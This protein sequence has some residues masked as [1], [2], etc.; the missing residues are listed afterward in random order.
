MFW[1]PERAPLKHTSLVMHKVFI[2]KLPKDTTAAVSRRGLPATV[3]N[4]ELRVQQ[5][6]ALVTEST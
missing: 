2:C 3:L 5:H 1:L 6:G 4:P